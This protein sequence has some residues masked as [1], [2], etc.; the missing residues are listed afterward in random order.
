ML[1]RCLID[2]ANTYP[3][4][5]GRNRKLPT[6]IF[7]PL[8]FEVLCGLSTD[9]FISSKQAGHTFPFRGKNISISNIQ[10]MEKWRA[11]VSLWLYNNTLRGAWHHGLGIKNAFMVQIQSKSSHHSSKEIKAISNT[12]MQIGRG[13]CAELLVIGIKV[14]PLEMTSLEPV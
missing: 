7:S 14:E 1:G 6:S 4:S 11:G 10:F 5:H 13:K 9:F 3:E 8:F 2:I 12:L